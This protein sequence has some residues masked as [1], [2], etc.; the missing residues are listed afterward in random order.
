MATSKCWSGAARLTDRA[1]GGTDIFGQ[2]TIGTHAAGRYRADRVPHLALERGAG[3]AQRQV[4]HVGGIFAIPPNLLLSNTGG[5]VDWCLRL[6][7][8]RQI[9][10]LGYQSRRR[11]NAQLAKRQRQ[12]GLA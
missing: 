12:H 6:K 5:S 11:P 1:R 9:A 3:F 2:F 8:G 4:E 10:Q 7:M